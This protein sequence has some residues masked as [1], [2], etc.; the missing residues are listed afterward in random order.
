MAS[1]FVLIKG[2]QPPLG[3]D[4]VAI[5][6]WELHGGLVPQPDLCKQYV[7]NAVAVIVDCGRRLGGD[8]VRRLNCFLSPCVA[9]V[10]DSADHHGMT[11]AHPIHVVGRVIGPLFANFIC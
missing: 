2:I 7:A 5:L 1:A 10:S 8:A 4:K 11:K 9:P 6:S 3:S